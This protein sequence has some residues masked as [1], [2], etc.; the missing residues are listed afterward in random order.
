MTNRTVDFQ[1]IIIS[2][3]NGQSVKLGKRSSM[4]PRILFY[5]Y[6]N[7]KIEHWMIHIPAV[8]YNNG[9]KMSI[10]KKRLNENLSFKI[11]LLGSKD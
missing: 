6:D 4:G 11:F 1:I 7:L 3:G 8:S 5:R 9:R 2:A 10:Y